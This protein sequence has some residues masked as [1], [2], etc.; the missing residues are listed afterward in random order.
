MPSPLYNAFGNQGNQMNDLINRFNQF[1][2][3]FNGNPQQM[4]QQ[5]LNS[6]R[7]T[8]NQFDQFKQ[9]ADQMRKFM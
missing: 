2:R 8:Q 7:M 4:V 5:L 9:M 6:G 3:S 1:K